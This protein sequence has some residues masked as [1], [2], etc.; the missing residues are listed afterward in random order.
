M[1]EIFD[2][3]YELGYVIMRALLSTAV[4]EDIMEAVE[5]LHRYREWITKESIEDLVRWSLIQIFEEME[6]NDP[7]LTAAIVRLLELVGTPDGINLNPE[8]P[9]SDGTLSEPILQFP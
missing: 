3:D 9:R 2:P 5:L 7:F 1:A 8:L 6:F 4:E